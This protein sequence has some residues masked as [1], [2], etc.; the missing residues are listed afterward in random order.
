M[1]ISRATGTRSSPSHKPKIFSVSSV[2]NSR[3]IAMARS[4][5]RVELIGNIGQFP[6]TRATQNGARVCT[7][8][9]ATS[10]RWRDTNGE[11]QERTQWHRCVAWSNRQ[12]GGITDVIQEYV[13][14]GDKI[15][16]EGR[17]EYR[18]WEDKN[19]VK[20]TAAEIR[21]LQMILLGHSDKR[22]QQEQAPPRREPARS[23]ATSQTGGEFDDFPAALQDEDDDLPF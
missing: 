18:Q 15:Y 20:H 8:S 1:F 16:I 7:F 11:Y 6:E 22:R 23:T 5:N 4:L 21:V 2:L 12:G 10:E 19:G 17:L 9:V 13:A 14:K 3:I